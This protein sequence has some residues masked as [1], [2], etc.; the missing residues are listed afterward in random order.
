MTA[1]PILP[2]ALALAALL[3]SANLLA[4]ASVQLRV[5]ETSD[6]HVHIVDYDYFQDQQSVTMGLARTAALIE[7]A[8]AEVKNSILVDNG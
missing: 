6:I 5:L 8:R 4:D 7:V 2:A 1:R 3:T